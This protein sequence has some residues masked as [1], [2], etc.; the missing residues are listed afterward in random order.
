ME[1]LRWIIAQVIAN[2]A[3][4][5][6][7][8]MAKYAQDCVDRFD[9]YEIVKKAGSGIQGTEFC[10]KFFDFFGFVNPFAKSKWATRSFTAEYYK[11]RVN[12]Y[13]TKAK[14]YKHRALSAQN[15]I[16]QK[17]GGIRRVW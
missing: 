11:Y 13:G 9:A 3:L 5:D 16:L 14:K 15:A 6:N 7:R 8:A 1:I 17:R 2:P 4:L 10:E 12:Y